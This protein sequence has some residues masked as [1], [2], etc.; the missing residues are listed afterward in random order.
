MSAS[1]MLLARVEI[2]RL[3]F[4]ANGSEEGAGDGAVEC[5][6]SLGAPPGV[7]LRRRRPPPQETHAE[8]ARGLRLRCAA[9]VDLQGVFFEVRQTSDAPA[10]SDVEDVRLQCG[11]WCR[12]RRC[13]Q[14]GA[15]SDSSLSKFSSL[16]CTDASEEEEASS[17]S[18]SSSS[19]SRWQLF[20]EGG[21]R[22]TQYGLQ[23]VELEVDAAAESPCGSLASVLFFVA[24]RLHCTVAAEDDGPPPR[25]R[26]EAHEIC[27][28][29]PLRAAAA[30]AAVAA[31]EENAG[32]SEGS[33]GGGAAATEA[34]SSTSSARGGEAGEPEAT[35]EREAPAVVSASPSAP[36]ESAVVRWALFVDMASWNWCLPA[37]EKDVECPSPGEAGEDA[38][39]A[40]ERLWRLTLCT[41]DGRVLARGS[42]FC[43]SV[44]CRQGWS[45]L[46]V[47]VGDDIAAATVVSLQLQSLLP[48]ALGA[49]AGDNKEVAFP[50]QD[51]APAPGC[52][53]RWVPVATSALLPIAELLVC[54]ADARMCPVSLYAAAAAADGSVAAPCSFPFQ[55]GQVVQAQAT[56]SCVSAAVGASDA[57]G[58]M[59]APQRVA[60]ECHGETL[61]L[62]RGSRPPQRPAAVYSLA[63]HVCFA[64]SQ[65]LC[66]QVDAG[67][68]Y[69]CVALAISGGCETLLEAAHEDD[70]AG[71]VEL[72][73]A[74]VM[75]FDARV[76]TTLDEAHPV[77]L[78]TL[79]SPVAPEVVFGRA[80]LSVFELPPASAGRLWIPLRVDREADRESAT[81]AAADD[82]DCDERNCA[83]W[84]HCGYA[85]ILRP[86]EHATSAVSLANQELLQQ[87]TP[88][89]APSSV[90]KYLTSPSLT[91]PLRWNCLRLC[92]V[93]AADFRGALTRSGRW[94]QT[95]G[96]YAEANVL[97]PPRAVGRT[98]SSTLAAAF[99]TPVLASSHPHWVCSSS[100]AIAAGTTH[101]L[102]RL[103]DDMG[104]SG[105]QTSEDTE[106]LGVLDI[107]R[108]AASRF[109]TTPAGEAWLP[110]VSPM[111]G[112]LDC[113][114]GAVLL[115]WAFS[116]RDYPSWAALRGIGAEPRP[117]WSP[118]ALL[119]PH[120]MCWVQLGCIE[121]LWT[122]LLHC[123]AWRASAA[124]V[125]LRRPS[126]FLRLWAGHFAHE[127]P[128]EPSC[129]GDCCVAVHTTV[130][131]PL[132]DHLE[133]ALCCSHDPRY[134]P[135]ASL[136]SSL[137]FLST[138]ETSNAVV[139]LGGGELLLSA[140]ARADI[141]ASQ[142]LRRAVIRIEP[143]STYPPCAAQA[144]LLTLQLQHAR[145]AQEEAADAHQR[146]QSPRWTWPP[147]PLSTVVEL[148]LGGVVVMN[149]QAPLV[150]SDRT[151]SPPPRWV[152]GV[153]E[154]SGRSGS[155]G[156][157]G[158]AG[159]SLDYI[160]HPPVTLNAT[161]AAAA[162]D[163]SA[164][165]GGGSL[166]LH[167]PASPFDN[168]LH[169][170]PP[171]PT[172]E[173]LLSREV[174]TTPQAGA[175]AAT[176][177]FVGSVTLDLSHCFE[178]A[179]GTQLYALRH[180]PVPQDT[181]G[182]GGRLIGF[183]EL[184]FAH[185]F[186]QDDVC[187]GEKA[188]V[189]PAKAVGGEGFFF[190]EVVKAHYRQ[191]ARL[192]DSTQ[193]RDAG[194]P[195]TSLVVDV[196]GT[197]WRTKPQKG[198]APCFDCQ[199]AFELPQPP[200]L[201]T[202]KRP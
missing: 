75:R 3:S 165:V 14:S 20:A 161:A 101:L 112:A 15:T 150:L 54:S 109:W 46:I 92:I 77:L 196:E 103:F 138:E 33:V 166:Y 200:K 198:M 160:I 76:Q 50:P 135:A 38:C 137:P 72:R 61:R 151:L 69:P 7:E 130:C 149:T 99:T 73:R 24:P 27:D 78:L 152:V 115:R 175:A 13:D 168:G 74:P 90:P 105:G 104:D 9:N 21:V 56:L 162:A 57:A 5:C 30:A 79:H 87:P 156:L 110:I 4:V 199:M 70:D 170:R 64:V 19:G 195:L 167:W 134:S 81:A 173:L 158:A 163:K 193:P 153:R 42:S 32:G 25:A 122:W 58:W 71:R 148:R 179:S 23:A 201:E 43:G 48:V 62:A 141:A 96:V 191:R 125:S 117:H 159:A 55:A 136:S 22:A 106:C 186:V 187:V 94:E 91:K 139:V 59:R 147:P 6:V 93:A 174:A 66:C 118:S 111:Q 39:T 85:C 88:L 120:G 65:R 189:A 82:D 131:L 26:L 45:D 100:L 124:S 188:A 35:Q 83:G 60:A 1:Q 47:A 133:A 86:D 102:I 89:P 53:L 182:G 171:P 190:M 10:D 176:T 34:A 84:L 98:D 177:E 113:Y 49:D 31:E 18:S 95:G 12:T 169:L 44:C 114:H 181:A 197:T 40:A 126:F 37:A 17:S 107:P 128:L 80:V 119:Q 121:L 145:I 194:E 155:S 154:K 28:P 68:A 157:H 172:V 16:P 127:L 108:F 52:P 202:G 146:P 67:A 180:P 144:G 97:P 36:A 178:G 41:A 183:A 51:N 132:S 129:E 11:L 140:E 63:L 142:Q 192:L 123:S 164:R 29:T 116:G 143:R 184:H 2:R 185:N 8:A